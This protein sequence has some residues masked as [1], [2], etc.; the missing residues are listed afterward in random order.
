MI[1]EPQ[2]GDDKPQAF[3]LE[4]DLQRIKRWYAQGELDYEDIY[5]S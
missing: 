1:G 4:A 2:P 5:E 3:E